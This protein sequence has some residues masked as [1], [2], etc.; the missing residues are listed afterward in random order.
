MIRIFSSKNQKIGEAGEVVAVKYLKKQDF[1][2]VERNV[3]NKFGEIDIVAK[4]KGI[5]YFFEVKTGKAGGYI[6]PT[7]NLHKDKIRKFLISVEHYCLLHGIRDYR[8][9]GIIVMQNIDGI[10]ST[11]TIDLF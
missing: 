9:E 7:E 3:S 4:K 1:I 2:V 8:A 11:E 5:H 10:Y 6:H